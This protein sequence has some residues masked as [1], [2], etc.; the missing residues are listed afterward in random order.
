MK[1]IKSLQLFILFFIYLITNIVAQPGFNHR[2]NKTTLPKHFRFMYNSD[3]NNT[4]LKDEDSPEK[5]YPFVDEV[6]AAGFT[7]YFIS[8]NIG[9]A[10]NYP[11]VVGD[12]IGNNIG[13]ELESTIKPDAPQGTNER[14]ILNLRTLISNGHD[15]LGILLDRAS[16]QHIETFIS[17]R[18]N[19]VH[20]VDLK[21]SFIFDSF[22]RKHPEWRIGEPGDSLSQIYVDILGPRTNPIVG[23][24]LPGGLNFAVPEVREYRLAQ[25]KE[26]CSRYNIDGL[27]LD[28]Q[29]FPMYFKPREEASNIKVMSDWMRQVR[30]MVKKVGEKRGRPVLL[31]ARIMALPEQNKAIGLDPVSWAHNGILDFVIVSHYLHNNF[32]LPIEEYRSLLPKGF[33]VY[34]SIEVEEGM[35]RYHNISYPLWQKNVNG[36][37]LFNF[38]TSRERGNPPPFDSIRTIGYPERAGDAVLLVANKHSN[39]LSYVNPKTFEIIATILTGPNPHEITL[40]PDQ[41]KAYLS[42]Y[43]PPGN[44]ISVIDLKERKLIKEI[45]TGEYGRIH[46]TAMSPDGRYAY[47]TAGQSGYVIEVKTQTNEISRTIPTH[48]K[49]SHMVY[50]SP[51]G[52]YLL[53]SNIV[54]EDISVINRTTGALIKK[55]P[56]GKG[57]EGMAFTPDRKFLW[58]LNQTGGT[59]TIIDMQTLEPTE[60]FDCPGMPVRIRFTADGKL[61]LVPGWTKEGTLTVIDVATHKELKRI[62]VGDFAIG[63]EISPDGKRAFVGCEDA[64]KTAVKPEGDEIITPSGKGSDGVHVINLKTLK[65]EAIIKTGLG[66]DPMV[67]WY[68]PND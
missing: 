65:V 13:E 16:A 34:A 60:T 23:G 46:G 67:M 22:W 45:T 29:R 10:M 50:V 25:L 54:S 6:A 30:S 24:W 28:F 5:L 1:Q 40:I 43:E 19:E 52:K 48:G 4:F 59:I 33:P 55:I 20:A 62:R 21:E 17:F 2:L 47:F 42:S 51:D 44:T 63:V 41:R 57:V 27:E 35:E 32:Q 15:P 14:V 66:P 36:I 18:L 68:P 39:T 7:S 58:A 64:G 38:F 53:T 37:Y 56:A 26:I 11:T 12:M 31:T 9:M 61:A 8:P 49:I 3:A